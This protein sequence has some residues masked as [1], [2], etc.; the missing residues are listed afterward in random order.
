MNFHFIFLASI[1]LLI[2]L[3]HH[4]I[5][6]YSIESSMQLC[7]VWWLRAVLCLHQRKLLQSLEAKRAFM[8]RRRL[9]CAIMVA[10]LVVWLNTVIGGV[11]LRWEPQTRRACQIS[12]FP[13]GITW[14]LNLSSLL[15]S[16]LANLCV[17][18]TRKNNIR[19]FSASLPTEQGWETQQAMS[20][21]IYVDLY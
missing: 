8:V 3:L 20:I 12:H 14:L 16:L 6:L 11:E 15:K 19:S 4:F 10:A 18:W 21:V 7:H 9:G 13:P 17:L 5:F 1:G 2:S